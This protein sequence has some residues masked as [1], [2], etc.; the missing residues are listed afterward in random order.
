MEWLGNKLSQVNQPLIV[1]GDF[2]SPVFSAPAINFI[3]RSGLKSAGSYLTTWP[4]HTRHLRYLK[5][6]IMQFG[7]DQFFTNENIKL[8]SKQRGPDLGSD[9]RPVVMRFLVTGDER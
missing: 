5:L 3:E 1:G 9:H 8:I 7:L 6:P 2:N 4:Q